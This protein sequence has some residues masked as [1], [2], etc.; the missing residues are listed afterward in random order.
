MH[1]LGHDDVGGDVLVLS[2]VLL[3]LTLSLV[4]SVTLG[5]FSALFLVG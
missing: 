3:L 1:V 5:L 4:L 2:A